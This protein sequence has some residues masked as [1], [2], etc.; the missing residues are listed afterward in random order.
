MK[1]VLLVIAALLGVSVTSAANAT[2]YTITALGPTFSEA[3]GINNRGQVAGTD[4]GA[5]TVWN[6]GIPTTLSP[7]GVSTAA[8]WALS[9][10]N[11]G[12]VAGLSYIGTVEHDDLEWNHSDRPRHARGLS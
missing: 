4:A 6:G 11:A 3:R 2:T 7:L 9:I 10:N 1:V 8:S 12:E 5:A